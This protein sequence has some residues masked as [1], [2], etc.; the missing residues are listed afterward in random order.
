MPRKTTTVIAHK[1]KG[2]DVIS[3]ER[4]LKYDAPKFGKGDLPSNLRSRNIHSDKPTNV[5]NPSVIPPKEAVKLISGMKTVADRQGAKYYKTEYLENHISASIF[6]HGKGKYQSD[7]IKIIMEYNPN[8]EFESYVED[9]T[10]KEWSRKRMYSD[11]MKTSDMMTQLIELEIEFK[12]QRKQWA[13]RLGISEKPSSKAH[14]AKVEDSDL[15]MNESKY[16]LSEDCLGSEGTD[17]Q[18]RSFADWLE[19]NKKIEI[20]SNG[21][22][23]FIKGGEDATENYASWIN[24]WDIESS[25]KASKM[26]NVCLSCGKTVSNVNKDG[27]CAACVDELEKQNLPFN[28]QKVIIKPDIKIQRNIGKS[29]YLVSYYTGKKHSDGSDFYDIAI[30]KSKKATDEFITSL[31]EDYY[32]KR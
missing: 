7:A 25:S 18:V 20:D 8:D 19:D 32:K 10:G 30:F 23:Y 14:N 27:E 15:S 29:K 6:L 12:E 22:Y 3:H 1:R 13:S 11:K 2:N 26:H 31:W 4:K 24:D 21:T 17:K 28:S 5:K 9:A 16:R